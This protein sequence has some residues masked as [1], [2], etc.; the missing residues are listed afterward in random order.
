MIRYPGLVGTMFHRSSLAA[1]K[2]TYSEGDQPLRRVRYK[3]RPEG[4]SLGAGPG[5]NAFHPGDGR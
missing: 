1:A 4:L 2:W 5:K 3:K